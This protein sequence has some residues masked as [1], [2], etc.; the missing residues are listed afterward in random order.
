M[1]EFPENRFVLA[2]RSAVLLIQSGGRR[3]PTK[4][5]A[6]VGKMGSHGCPLLPCLNNA[7]HK[8]DAK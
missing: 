4:G 5:H 3:L 2:I 7:Q 8:S 1:S 6:Y